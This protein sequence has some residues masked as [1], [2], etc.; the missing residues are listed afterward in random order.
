MRTARRRPRSRSSIDT[1]PLP[2]DFPPIELSISDPARM[3]PGVTLF[4]LIHWPESGTDAAYGLLVALNE[5]G[6]VVW[7]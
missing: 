7:Y 5:R 3:E 2:E 1:P 6:E 4:D